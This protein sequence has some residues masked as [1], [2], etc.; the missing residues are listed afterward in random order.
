MFLKKKYTTTGGGLLLL[1]IFFL[2]MI[3]A[4]EYIFWNHGYRAAK[5]EQCVKGDLK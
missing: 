3:V 5:Q 1:M 2:I 4:T